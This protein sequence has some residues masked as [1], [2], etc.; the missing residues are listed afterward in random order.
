MHKCYFFLKLVKSWVL[1][2]IWKTEIEEVVISAKIWTADFLRQKLMWWPRDHVAPTFE[3]TKLEY[4]F[5]D[6]CIEAI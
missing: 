3:K 4:F 6:N 1:F 2:T 5:I